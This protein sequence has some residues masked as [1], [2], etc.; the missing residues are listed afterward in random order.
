MEE[1]SYELPS[2][3]SYNNSTTYSWTQQYSP[4]QS[5]YSTRRS[6]NYG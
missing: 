5:F 1:N 6:L 2:R 3:S 4:A